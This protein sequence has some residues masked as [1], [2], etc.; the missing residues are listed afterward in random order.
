MKII[1]DAIQRHP[2]GGLV[3]HP[4]WQ[5]QAAIIRRHYRVYWFD[6]PKGDALNWYSWLCQ[7][8]LAALLAGDT[9]PR[10]GEQ[11]VWLASPYHAQLARDAFHLT[12]FT[13]L[14]WSDE[15]AA[16]MVAQLNP[17][18]AAYDMRLVANGANLLLFSRRKLDAMPPSLAEISACG[19][20]NR[21]VPGQDGMLLM[22]IMAEIQTQLFQYSR[23][24]QGLSVSGLWLWGA[25][26]LPLP[27]VTALPVASNHALLPT[28]E[29]TPLQLL[30]IDHE[31]GVDIGTDAMVLAVSNEPCAALLKRRSSLGRLFSPFAGNGRPWQ[32]DQPRRENHLLRQY[33]L[34]YV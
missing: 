31:V 6:A 16:R 9:L 13:E 1:I 34:Q 19:L 17:V 28:C 15:D 14:T 5:S 18:L 24:S 2:Q 25:Q 27:E 21:T 12:S 20:P 4:L 11:Q 30:H 26:P 32:A 23:T 33:I 22:R 10:D 29:H 8:S 3:L 7:A